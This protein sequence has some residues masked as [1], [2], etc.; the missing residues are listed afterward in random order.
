MPTPRTPRSGSQ[1]TK[2]SPLSTADQAATDPTYT[3]GSL[4]SQTAG[5]GST[6]GGNSG[7]AASRQDA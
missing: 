7:S 1:G 6:L 3:A 2:S 4:G 5:Q